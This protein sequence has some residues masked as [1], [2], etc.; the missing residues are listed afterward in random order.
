MLQLQC[1]KDGNV[2]NAN[3]H[4]PVGPASYSGYLTAIDISGSRSSVYH[5]STFPAA[6]VLLRS[7]GVSITLKSIAF[8]LM[9]AVCEPYDPLSVDL[10][11]C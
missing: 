9:H 8:A 7:C 1:P 2:K 5:L 3:G 10:S 4:V 11:L 6:H